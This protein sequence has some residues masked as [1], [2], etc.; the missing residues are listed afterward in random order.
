MVGPPSSL[1]SIVKEQGSE[2]KTEA[3]KYTYKDYL[4]IAQKS[5][6]RLEIL[7]GVL[8]KKLPPVVLHQRITR[9]FTRI[10]EDYFWQYDPKGEVFGAP[11]TVTFQDTTV[12]QPDLFYIS[13]QQTEIVKEARI[14]GPPTLIAEITFSS[15]RRKD[16]LQKMRIYQR[17]QVPHYWIVDPDEKTLECYTLQNNTYALIA[18]G[19]EDEVVEHQDFPELAIKLKTLWGDKSSS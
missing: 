9:R 14:D 10:L 12:V 18:S 7:D 8:V 11:L 16:R 5:S 6:Y 1:P 19:M 3:K 4:L 15:S 13:S 17:E 2:Y